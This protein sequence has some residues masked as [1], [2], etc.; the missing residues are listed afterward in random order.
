MRVAQQQP[1]PTLR[2]ESPE[3]DIFSYSTFERIHELWSRAPPAR[4][5]LAAKCIEVGRSNRYSEQFQI[6]EEL[7]LVIDQVLEIPQKQGE[8]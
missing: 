1:S 8:H 3:P 6:G 4:H 2:P 5:L 7:V